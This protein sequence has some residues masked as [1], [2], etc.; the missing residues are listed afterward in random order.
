VSFFKDNFLA[1]QSRELKLSFFNRG[2]DNQKTRF[3][4]SS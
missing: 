1:S 4:R 3:L 2:L